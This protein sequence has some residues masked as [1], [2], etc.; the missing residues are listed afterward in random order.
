[1]RGLPGPPHHPILGHLPVIA[2]LKTEYP[3]DIH[4]HTYPHLVRDKY[5]LGDIYYLDFWPASPQMLI[6]ASP[7]LA[8]QVSNWNKHQIVRD[9][10]PALTGYHNMIAMEGK[11]WKTWRSIFNPGFSLSSLMSLV[12]GIVEDSLVFCDVLTEHAQKED[13]FRLEEAATR[14]TIDIIGKVIL[15]IELNSQR[16]DNELLDALR[17]Q[18]TWLFDDQ[19][20]NPFKR[21]RPFRPLAVWWYTRRMN[22]YIG[23]VLD[24]R[25]SSRGAAQHTD[26]KRKPVI[27]RALD[28]YLEEEKEGTSSSTIL[29]V[30]KTFKSYAIDQMKTF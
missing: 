2:R 8:Q 14:L 5:G 26:P 27:D 24:K 25:F 15:D 18:I 7:E 30:D 12:P 21:W 20:F 22:Q 29:A 23:N 19:E 1:M 3:S 16:E 4:P 6:I 11:E 9:I 28:A 17:S 10:L 13:V